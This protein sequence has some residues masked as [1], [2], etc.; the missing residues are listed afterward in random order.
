V[1]TPEGE[2]KADLTGKASGR[3]AYVCPA[4][5]CLRLAFKQ[6]KFERALGK[7]VSEEV[8]SEMAGLAAQG[9]P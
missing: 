6:K 4:E 3:G 7:S 8:V 2:I 9:G 1:R 5:E